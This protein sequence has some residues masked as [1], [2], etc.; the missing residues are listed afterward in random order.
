[1]QI[2]Q[3]V[4]PV[5]L[6]RIPAEVKALKDR[7]AAIEAEKRILVQL[8]SMVREGCPHEGAQTGYNE[9]DGNWMNPCP[10]CGYSY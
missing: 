4:F 2:P 7:L 6:E 5:E 8:L 1:M 10:T 9:R 3:I